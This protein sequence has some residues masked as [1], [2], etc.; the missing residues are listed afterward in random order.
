MTKYQEFEQFILE[1]QN[2]KSNILAKLSQAENKVELFRSE[3][4]SA[5]AMLPVAMNQEAELRAKFEADSLNIGLAAEFAIWSDRSKSYRDRIA[6]CSVAMEAAQRDLSEL[7]AKYADL[8]PTPYA[9][10]AALEMK[11]EIDRL[12]GVFCVEINMALDKR[13]SYLEAIKKVYQLQG[14]GRNATEAGQ[15]A[16]TYSGKNILGHSI[17]FST[18]VKQFFISESDVRKA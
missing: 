18:G 1:L 8:D 14:I 17:A 2:N 15:R 16:Q 13:K 7:E 10:E 9:V 6:T 4:T 3:M 12:Y 11:G 5:Q